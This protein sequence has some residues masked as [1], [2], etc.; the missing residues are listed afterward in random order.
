M[1]FLERM[2]A[3]ANVEIEEVLDYDV[4][5]AELGPFVADLTA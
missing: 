5:F 1:E 4:T 3:V 2:M